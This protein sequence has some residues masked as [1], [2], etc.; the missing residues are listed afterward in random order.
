MLR[1]SL[2]CIVLVPLL[3]ACNSSDESE[4]ATVVATTTHVADLAQSVAGERLD[5][6][7]LL[8][9][10]SD[11]HEYEPR[12]SDA[13]AVSSASIVFASG[14]EVDQWAAELIDGSGSGAE[15]VTLL[16]SAPVTRALDGETDP[17]WWQDP[18]NAG[19]AVE[20]IRDELSEADPEGADVYDQNASAYISAIQRSDRTITECMR[21]LPESARK[22]VTSHDSLGYFADRYGIEVVGAAIPALSTQAQPSTGE[23]ARL[24]DLLES[25]GVRAVFPEAGLSGDLEEAIAAEAGVEVGG[26]LYADSLGENGTPGDTYLGALEANA[27]AIF[28]ALSIDESAPCPLTDSDP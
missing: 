2:I 22:L 11:P 10:N 24:V 21:A 20:T 17:H 7:A 16:A 25:E 26:E 8:A 4:D 15:V 23:T 6:Q 18:R 1:L 9:P 28:T 5:V 12:P 3:T 13:A 14:G 27:G 19:A